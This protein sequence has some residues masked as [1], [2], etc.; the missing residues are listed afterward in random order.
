MNAAVSR[1]AVPG[2]PLLL[3]LCR[4][5]ARRLVT[6]PVFLVALALGVVMFVTANA[7]GDGGYW[8]VTGP[9]QITLALGTLVAAN[10]AALRSRGAGAGEL[11]EPLV[12]G[13]RAVTA[14]QLGAVAAAVGVAGLLVG[15]ELAYTELSDA[16]AGETRP[17]A[18]ALLAGPVSV[19]ACGA[20]GLALARW[21]PSAALAVIAVPALFVFAGRLPER[22]GGPIVL[23]AAGLTVCLGALALLR[24]GRRTPTAV[25]AA[26][27]GCAFVAG[28]LVELL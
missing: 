14:A 11:L 15:V 26:A 3:A 22:A 17:S 13:E 19:S 16:A 6:H 28:T 8:M 23:A 20:L 25:A 9:G 1:R 7:A 21:A 12:L 10:L 24:H 2:T 27:G 5:E 18:L 4:V